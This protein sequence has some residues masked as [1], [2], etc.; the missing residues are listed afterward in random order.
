MEDLSTRGHTL[1]RVPVLA[2]GAPELALET[3]ADVGREVMRLT[4]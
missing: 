4:A 3:L 1:N 2:F